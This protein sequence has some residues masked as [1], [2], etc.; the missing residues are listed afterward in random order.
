MA[1]Q[2]KGYGGGPPINSIGTSIVLYKSP[3]QTAST[4]FE[5]TG[6]AGSALGSKQVI[7]P[8]GDL[9]F[10]KQECW[11][12]SIVQIVGHT[13]ELEAPSKCSQSDLGNILRSR[14]G[15]LRFTRN[16]A[17]SPV[18]CQIVSVREFLQGNLSA[19]TCPATLRVSVATI[20]ACHALIDRV[21][22]T[23]HTVALGEGCY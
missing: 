11:S 18:L 10:Q 20:S 21:S 16:G 4:P 5:Q 23:K 12:R 17:M 19:G 8:Q 1:V 22:A 15:P 14:S 13:Q 9:R 2:P 7:V 3:G 6:T